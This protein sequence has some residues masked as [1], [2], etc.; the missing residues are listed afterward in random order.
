MLRPARTLAVFSGA[1]ASKESG[2]P[3][4][5]EAQT[6]LWARY[7]PQ[8]LATPAAFR[9]DPKLVWEW[10]TYRRGLMGSVEPNP[11]HLAR[12]RVGGASF[13]WWC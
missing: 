6:G 12:G 9:R 3:T 5:R 10:Y 1:G 8:Q 2:I 4:F 11:G 13:R 7:D